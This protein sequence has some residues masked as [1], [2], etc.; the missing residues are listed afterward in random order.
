MG[1]FIISGYCDNSLAAFTPQE[2]KPEFL[3]IKEFAF[4]PKNAN[5]LNKVS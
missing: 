5:Q 3:K 4:W 1:D 2:G